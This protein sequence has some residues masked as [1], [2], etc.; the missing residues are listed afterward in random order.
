MPM[1]EMLHYV[2]D[3]PPGEPSAKVRA[4]LGWVQDEQMLSC[5]LASA[6]CGCFMQAARSLNL[7]STLLRKKLAQLEARV[8]YPLFVNR[9]H[10]L[11]LSREGRQLQALLQ[12]SLSCKP[13]AMTAL[14]APVLV[15]LAVAEPIMQDILGRNLVAFVRQNAGIRLDVTGLEAA[16]VAQADVVLWLDDEEGALPVAQFAGDAPT[17]LAVLEYHP[18]IAKRYSRESNRPVCRDD[19]RDY[20]LVQWQGEAH[21]AALAPWNRLLD[22]REAGVTRVPGYDLFSQLIKCSACIGV[23]PHYAAQLDRGL[24]ALPG[25]LEAPMRRTV[26]LAVHQRAAQAP[27]VQVLVAMVRAAFEER[28]EWF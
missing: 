12:A 26:W 5:F 28:R 13:Q 11:V 4:G 3:Y 16:S 19:L 24:L 8:G 9:G 27:L 6:R 18:H 1:F 22:E 15:R 25:L 2:P 23:L 21:V 14:D 7:K 10:A 20:M 17:R